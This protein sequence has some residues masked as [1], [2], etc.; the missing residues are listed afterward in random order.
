[1]HVPCHF[2]SETN[3]NKES[4]AKRDWNKSHERVSGVGWPLNLLRVLQGSEEGSEIGR[5]SHR[6]ERTDPTNDSL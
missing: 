4:A 3:C 2:E 5:I 6:A 1:M